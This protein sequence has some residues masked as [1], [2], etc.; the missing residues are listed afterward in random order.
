MQY[1]EIHK[2]VRFVVKDKDDHYLYVVPAKG[3]D[4]WHIDYHQ[5]EQTLEAA[6]M[7]EV[8]MQLNGVSCHFD[9]EQHVVIVDMIIIEPD[10]LIDVTA[11]CG[12]LKTYGD[13]ALNYLVNRIRPDEQTK[14]ILLG[15]VA[16]QFLDDCINDP[17][18]TYL[19]SIRHAFRQNILGFSTCEG[20]DAA[21]FKE[22]ERQF[23]NIQLIVAQMH[24]DPNFIGMDAGVQLEPS[25]FCEAL[26]IQ[27]RFDFLQVDC[28]NLI[29]LKSGKWDT[30]LQSAK[31]EHIMQMLLYK[32]ILYY[33]LGISQDAI[34]GYLLYSKYPLLIEQR[35]D[36]EMIRKM[37]GLRNQVVM[38]ERN[39]KDGK[40]AQYLSLLQAEDLNVNHET[41]K[42]WVQYNLP[43]LQ[44]VLLPIHQMDE[45]TA[46]YF[47]TFFS[48]VVREQY[49]QKTADSMD[50][51]RAMSNL[52]NMDVEEKLQNGDIVID[53]QPIKVEMTSIQMS[54]SEDGFP[55]REGDSVVLYRR[56]NENDTAVN[57]QV[58]R[59]TVGP[60][61]AHS[62]MLYLKNPQHNPR[63]FA[64]TNRFA[65]EADYID[66]TMRSQYHGLY[67]LLTVPD[68]RRQLLLCQRNP[69]VDDTI[70]LS[71]KYITK[72]IDEIVLS[73]KQAQDYYLLVG[74]PGTGKT[75]VALRSMV[76]EFSCEGQSLLLLAYTNRAVDEICEMLGNREYIRIGREQTCAPQFRSRLIN[77]LV[78]DDVKRET[79]HQMINVANI[80]VA[81]VSAMTSARHLFSLKQFDVAIFDEA[82]QILEPQILP[83]LCHHIEEK[84]SIKKFV[85]I[86]DHKQLPAVVVQDVEQSAVNSEQLRRI[87]LTNCRNSLFERLLLM[88]V[89]QGGVMATLTHQGRMHYDIS[90][91]VSKMF[92]NGNLQIVGL[93]HQT[94]LL[95][96][97]GYETEDERIVATSRVAFIDV[98]LPP[99]GERQFKV[100]KLEADKIAGLVLALKTVAERNGESFNPLCQ[101]G[102]IVPFRRQVAAVRCALCE[103]GIKEASDIMIDTVERY[104]GSQR[105]VIIFGTTITDQS[106][107]EILSNL[108]ELDGCVVDR[109][110]NVAITRA[111]KQL[112]IVGN[113]QL[114]SHHVL[115][116][117]L[118]DAVGRS[119]CK[120]S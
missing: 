103:M 109:K 102:I 88:G 110:L 49:Q 97:S 99:K 56:E 13:T 78:G 98:P 39:L 116:G 74:P 118:I 80:V 17:N 60:Y 79:V 35:S 87:G 76:D 82:S 91:I 12:C 57:R 19:E 2:A 81:T 1:E 51:G 95:Q 38:M 108:V 90:D 101:L 28:K 30:F 89:Q 31:R 27:G 115:Y 83:L 15:N 41:G 96:Y 34:N 20:V 16:G 37:M 105:D 92:Y 21:F 52:W 7:L 70:T 68:D 26:G 119:F 47:Y 111:R 55:F 59:C 54:L 63:M 93:P 75:S 112:F 11:L 53:M 67:A 43:E 94:E 4:S 18:V 50:S 32:E 42:L 100:N 9:L 65:I 104:Q 45:L 10:L 58:F 64:S 86:G 29:E 33:N 48:F 22:C 8:G 114:L 107:L 106:Q 61:D 77:N 69:V 72:E 117:R 84:L 25:F 113:Q 73:A 14:Y 85:L 44:K 36:R 5:N 24:A 46:D 6:S 3:G 62:V 71:G 40:V 120:K 23:R 66:S